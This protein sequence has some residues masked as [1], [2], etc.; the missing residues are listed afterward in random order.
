MKF[1]GHVTVT[2]KRGVFDP[3][4]VTVKNALHN[5]SFSETEAVRTGKYFEVVMESANPAEAEK[6]LNE[7]CD[8][9]L[10][11]PVIEC[12]RCHVEPAEEMES[13]T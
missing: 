4:G 2:L 9:L 13:A 3:Q 6:R 12:Y 7:M 5:L 10:V 8:R 11:N 1:L